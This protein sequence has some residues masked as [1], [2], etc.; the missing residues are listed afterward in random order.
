MY[1]VAN[2]GLRALTFENDIQ[3][4][5]QGDQSWGRSRGCRHEGL[6]SMVCVCVCVCMCVYKNGA[7]GSFRCVNIRLRVRAMQEHI[8]NT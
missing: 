7:A 2:K 6:S 5:E 3:G 8:R 1:R 4:C